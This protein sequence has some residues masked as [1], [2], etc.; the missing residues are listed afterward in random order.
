MEA[1]QQQAVTDVVAYEP[2]PLGPKDP[3]ENWKRWMGAEQERRRRREREARRKYQ[4]DHD[5][6]L[7]DSHRRLKG[8]TVVSVRP[9]VLPPVPEDLVERL[10]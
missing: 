9:G 2:D 7:F 3:S 5:D 8:S 6:P 1:E 4:N 10:R